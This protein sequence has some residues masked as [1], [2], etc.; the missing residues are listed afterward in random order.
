V[1]NQDWSEET[2]KDVFVYGKLVHDFK[3]VDYDALS[4]LNIS[5]TQELYRKIEA[6][7]KQNEQLQNIQKVVL[8]LKAEINNI[9]SLPISKN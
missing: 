3:T 6:L 5:A 2:L 9:K 4:M 8:E 1:K 7:E